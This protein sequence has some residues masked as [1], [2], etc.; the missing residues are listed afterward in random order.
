MEDDPPAVARAGVETIAVVQDPR[1]AQ[2]I[3]VVAH[4]LD[5]LRVGF[6][7]AF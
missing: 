7:F 5:Q 6:E 4:G 1:F 3:V 2:G